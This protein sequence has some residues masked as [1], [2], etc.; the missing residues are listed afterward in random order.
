MYIRVGGRKGEKGGDWF[1]HSVDSALS[2]CCYC[3]PHYEGGA[4]PQLP[5][6]KEVGGERERVRERE[7]ER[8]CVEKISPFS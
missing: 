2:S 6:I 7:R 1:R 8:S 4:I 5:H 3:E